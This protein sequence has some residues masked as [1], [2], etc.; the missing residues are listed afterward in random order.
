[1][2]D[3]SSLLYNPVL[4]E[5]PV[6]WLESHIYLPRETSPNQPGMISLRRQ[7]WAREILEAVMD[8]RINEIDLVCGAQLGKSTLL[9]LA[10]LLWAQFEPGP[11][12]LGMS[13]DDLAERFVKDRMYPLLMNNEPYSTLTPSAKNGLANVIRY[14]GMTTFFTGS[15][16]PS[17][18][19]SFP[20]KYLILDEVCKWSTGSSK[21][22]HPLFLVKER[23][24]SFPSHKM[25]LASTPT[26]ED[27]VFYQDYLH[28]SQSQYFMPCPHCGK[29]IKFEF[30]QQ[31][32]IWEPG[33][34]ATIRNT[35]HYECPHC[36]GEIWD[37]DK[38][39]M[40]EK[41]HWVKGRDNHVEGHLGFHLNSLY[42]PFVSFGDVAVEFTKS[43][44]SLLKSEALRNFTNSWLALPWAERVLKS[45][46]ADIRS[47]ICDGRFMRELPDDL[48]YLVCGIDPG[49]NQSHWCVSAVA[50]DGRIDVIDYGTIGSYSSAGGAF[51]PKKLIET[52]EYEYRGEP[53]SVDICF[54]DAGYSTQR[55]YEECLSTNVP[56][57]MRPTKGTSSNKGPFGISAVRN[58][59]D[60]QL[61]TYSDFSL[62]SY[63]QE[64]MK[65]GK[66][67]LPKDVEQ[68]FIK[69]IS[70]QELIRDKKGK[71]SWKELREDHFHD[72]L[73]LCVFST[74]IFNAPDIDADLE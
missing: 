35:A 27:D 71:L 4:N 18:L 68:E 47:L 72:C 11:C 73:K 8:P 21:E 69:G 24:K 48:D 34:L 60:L 17:R 50:L 32:L 53:K 31:T 38:S 57:I 10:W 65:D 55:I 39:D 41:G 54:I 2:K 15:R 36:S 51:G 37:K 12:L 30:S 59:I 44:A 40:M 19:S 3:F 13:T 64:M 20:A 22:S 56:E 5:H 46:E 26:A 14:P 33:S 42:S 45:S 61:Y 7:P 70:G 62:K 9:M 67:T 1:M 29:Y 6:D 58:E 25:I 23:V 43:N 28:S 52:L 66:I 49:V 74:W 16:S 63:T